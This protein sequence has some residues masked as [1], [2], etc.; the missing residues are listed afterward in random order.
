MKDEQINYPWEDAPDW[1]KYTAIDRNGDSYWYERKPFLRFADWSAIAGYHCK[2]SN[3]AP[4]EK[5]NW[6]ESLQKRPDGS[7]N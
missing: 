6:K 3:Y 5:F 1:A 7:L 4:P 2:I